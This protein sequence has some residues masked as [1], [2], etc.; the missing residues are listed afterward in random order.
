LYEV[1]IARKEDLD[2]AVDAAKHAFKSW[3]LT[4]FSKR[5]ELLL[6]YANLIEEHRA[7]FEKL[8]TLEQGK[9]LSLSNTEV[10]F[11]LTWLRAFATMEIKDEVLQ[12]DE[13]KIVYSTYPPIG[14]C[15]GIVSHAKKCAY[16]C[17]LICCFR[18]QVPWNW[19]I[20]LGLGKL[21]PALITGNTFIMK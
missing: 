17:S 5:A 4:P 8:L 18:K 20:L 1:P 6:E 2:A 21:G 16:K 11:G 14:V 10:S 19:P 3:S 13:E 9:P 7:E 15:A 12:E